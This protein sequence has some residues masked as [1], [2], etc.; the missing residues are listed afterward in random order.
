MELVNVKSGYIHLLRRFIDQ[1]G[2]AA[3]TFRY[4]SKR[5]VEVVNSHLATFLLIENEQPVA[6]GH[7]EDEG[8]CVWLGICVLPDYY[9][10]GYGKLMM[11]ALVDNAKK[12]NVNTISLTVDKV[13]EAAIRLYEHFNFQKLDSVDSYYK[14]TLDITEKI[15][16]KFNQE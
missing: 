7:L 4:F 10:K 3:T 8:G 9:G 15:P 2:I 1:M 12:L 16:Q 14:Y 11:R 6:Y 5:P 13:N